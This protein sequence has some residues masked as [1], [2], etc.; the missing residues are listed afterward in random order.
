MVDS[1]FFVPF[2]NLL[3]QIRSGGRSENDDMF[4]AEDNNSYF[5]NGNDGNDNNIT[6][7]DDDDDALIGLIL[8]AIVVVFLFALVVI[9]LCCNFLIDV[10]VLS[11]FSAIM[12]LKQQYLAIFH[13]RRRISINTSVNANASASTTDEEEDEHAQQGRRTFLDDLDDN[14]GDDNDD[15]DDDEDEDDTSTVEMIATKNL[16]L[17]LTP[18]EKRDILSSVLVSKMVTEN[19]LNYWMSKTLSSRSTI[20]DDEDAVI[21]WNDLEAGK[22]SSTGILTSSKAIATTTTTTNARSNNKNSD[23][24][25]DGEK[26]VLL[27]CPICIN[28]IKVGEQICHS[29][30][31]NNIDCRRHHHFHLNCLLDWLSTGS[32]ICPYCRS[33]IVTQNILQQKITQQQQQ[34]EIATTCVVKRH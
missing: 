16:L 21:I 20:V 24:D 10:F 14:D 2:G 27:C 22:S 29:K 23:D 9:R 1:R 5:Y 11:N 19:D 6:I 15:D 4:V 3:D 25:N 28:D 26:L 31:N 33:V 12:K 13:H 34:K 30:H 8:I 7:D 18:T 32:T 17:G